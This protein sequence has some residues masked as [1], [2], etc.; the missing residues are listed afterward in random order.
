MS[1]QWIDD[2]GRHAV[3]DV[4]FLRRVCP[5]GQVERY[6]LDDRP[7]RTNRSHEPR[8]YGWC[9]ETQNVNVYGAGMARVV[10]VAKNG[11]AL[12]EHLRGADLVHALEETGYPELAEQS[13]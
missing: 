8:L 7:P 5:Q 9:G 12:I 10:R 6:D 13:E 1:Q 4:G 2:D 3:G 11:R